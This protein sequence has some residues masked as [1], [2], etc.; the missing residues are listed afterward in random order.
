M[1][2]SS[3]MLTRMG[4]KNS[5]QSGGKWGLKVMNLYRFL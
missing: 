4:A 2:E 3:G 1:K 5:K